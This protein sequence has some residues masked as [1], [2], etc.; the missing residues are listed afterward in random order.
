MLSGVQVHQATDIET[1]TIVMRS[2]SRTVREIIAKHQDL[3]KF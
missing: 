1:H 3:D 2:S